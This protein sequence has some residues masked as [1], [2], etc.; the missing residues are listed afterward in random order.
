LRPA[1]AAFVLLAVNPLGL[2]PEH[3]P[4]DH[5]VESLERIV[6]FGALGETLV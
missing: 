2:S 5:R 4:I 1:A 3:L 6:R